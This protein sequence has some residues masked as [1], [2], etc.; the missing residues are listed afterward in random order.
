MA[1]R[2][3]VINDTEDILES[4]RLLLEGE[5]YEVVLYSYAPHDLEEVRRVSP[6]LIILDL[7]FGQEKY[8]FNLLEAM[9]MHRDLATI[10]VIICSAALDAVRQMQGY[11]TAHNVQVVLK[12]FD[13]DVLLLAVQQAFAMRHNVV[14]S[15]AAPP[16]KTPSPDEPA[17]HEQT[18]KQTDGQTDGRKN[19]HT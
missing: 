13:I 17:K 14:P 6:D 2:I 11:L 9:K 12:P 7:V 18:G 5:G 10:P 1:Q 15:E 16:G 19:S 8:G 4:F 3:L